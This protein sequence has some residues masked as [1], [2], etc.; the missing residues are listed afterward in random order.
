MDYVPA[1]NELF[2][3]AHVKK[4]LEAYPKVLNY[5]WPAFLAKRFDAVALH[6]DRT[7]WQ[8]IR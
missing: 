6:F 5:E 4:F 2:Y 8:R 1:Q 3:L 7:V